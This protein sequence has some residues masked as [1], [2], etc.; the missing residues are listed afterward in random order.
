MTRKNY[1]QFAQEL[2]QAVGGKANIVSVT[3]CMTR[4]RFVLKDESVAKD[5]EVQ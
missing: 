5:D 1:P 4:L 3:N 2:V